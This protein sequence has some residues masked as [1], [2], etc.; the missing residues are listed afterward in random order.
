VGVEGKTNS[1]MGVGVSGLASSTVGI[2]YGVLGT[3]YSIAGAGVK[4]ETFAPTGVGV[5]GA[6]LSSSGVNIGVYGGTT[7]PFG[8]AGYFNGNVSITGSLYKGTDLFRIDHPLDPE[9]KYLQH[10][11]I[12]S[13]EMKNLYDGVVVLDGN[14]EAWVQLPAWFEALNKD[15]RYQL[16][17]VGSPGP[18][19]HIAEKL[20]NN[21]FKIAGGDA[22]MEV[23]WQVTGVRHDA[24]AEAHPLVVEL[25]KPEDDVGKYLYPEEHGLP[26]S[27][28]LSFEPRAGGTDRVMTRPDPALPMQPRWIPDVE[29]GD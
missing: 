7:S 27:R 1:P 2:N 28:G 3:S 12:E 25:A 20:S 14:G 5:L 23:S 16:T 13:S 26:Q 4:G 9:R 6:A 8:W 10:A 24:Y 22:G 15:F 11:V 18:N 17:P 19:L 21:R 29:E